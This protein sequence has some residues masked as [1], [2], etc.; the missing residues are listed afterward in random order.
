M[1]EQYTFRLTEERVVTMRNFYKE[2]IPLILQSRISPQRCHRFALKWL[3]VLARMVFAVGFSFIILYPVLNMLSRAFMSPVDLYDN[4]ILWLPRHVTMDNFKVVI[5]VMNYGKSLFNSIWLTILITSLQ[6]VSCLMAGYG[7][8]R[9][10]FRFKKLLFACV[11]LTLI[12]P[13]QLV[14]LSTYMHFR[15]FDI[16][17][18]IRLITGKNGVNLL[19]T[20]LPSLLLAATANG[21]KNGLFIF[22]FRQFFRGMPKE[23]EEAAIVDGAGA[24][25]TFAQI[26]V[27]GAVTCIVTVVLFSVVWQWNDVF[28]S[29]MFFKDFKVLP[30]M[31]QN[32]V[33]MG[34]TEIL[35][36]NPVLAK[37]NLYDP[38]IRS[39]FSSTGVL[40]IILP[41]LLFFLFMQR[42][43][44]ESIER[45]GLVG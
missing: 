38:V 33:S 30:L 29:S 39:N 42:Y 9:Y 24:V 16:F 44:V 13:P 14:M 18:I 15:F 11:I 12:I 43:F 19:D 22:L 32:L 23:T 45:S 4:T 5:S 27:P 41:L 7:F 20:P 35:N 26:M 2:A 31:Y 21:I 1:G 37:Y 6:T 3:W 40:M 36:T 25:R 34:N 10:D 28:F 8:A 17:G